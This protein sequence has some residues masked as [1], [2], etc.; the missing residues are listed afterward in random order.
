M[1][2]A[3]LLILGALAG[4]AAVVARRRGQ[5]SGATRPGAVVA[6]AGAAVGRVVAK[7]TSGAGAAAASLAGWGVGT[8]VSVASAGAGLAVDASVVALDLGA[9]VALGAV[10]APLR[11]VGALGGRNDGRR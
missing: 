4:G 3:D 2:P 10:T 7:G 6:D 9:R 11:A 5:E 1:D 8:A